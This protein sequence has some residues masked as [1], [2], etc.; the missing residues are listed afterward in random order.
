VGKLGFEIND[1]HLRRAG[2]DY[3]QYL[4]WTYHTS[5]DEWLRCVP[6]KSRL[7]LFSTK[8]NKSYFEHK[9]KKGD[10]L[11]FGKETKGL[12]E[13]FRSQFPEQCV[14]MPMHGPIRSLNLSNAA[15]AAVYE[16]YRQTL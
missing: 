10:W 4:K 5:I 13:E 1:K 12:S 11:V 6:D 8:A 16:A 3:W 14:K 2:L 9:F 7:V 15:T